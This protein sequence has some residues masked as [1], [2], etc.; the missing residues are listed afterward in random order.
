[1]AT[2]CYLE[3]TNFKYKYTGR[4]Q[5]TRIEKLCIMDVSQVKITMNMLM[6][7]EIDFWT[8]TLK[9]IQSIHWDAYSGIKVSQ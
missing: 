6:S 4:F 3:H 7:D 1:M 2:L 8:R 9:C 5:M